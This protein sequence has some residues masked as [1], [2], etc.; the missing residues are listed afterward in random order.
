MQIAAIDFVLP[1]LP[2][3]VCKHGL[4]NIVIILIEWGR[5]SP[6]KSLRSQARWL[7]VTASSVQEAVCPRVK[8]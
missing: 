8:W 5:I 7:L 2:A 3:Q 1:A 6:V 4:R